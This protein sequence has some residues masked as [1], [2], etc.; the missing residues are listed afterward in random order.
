MIC[1]D[2]FRAD[3]I[4]A[5]RENPTTC[6]PHLDALCS[7]GV[8]FKQAISNQPLCSPSR[9]SFLASR[10]ATETGVWKLGLEMDH[11]L[12]TIAT[13]FKQNGYTTAFVGKWHVSAVRPVEGVDQSGWIAP[14]PSRGGFDQW[15]GANVLERV[16]HPYQGSYW[17]NDGTNIGFKDEYRVDFIT[18]RSINFIQQPHDKPWL[19]FVSQLEPH[20]QND[21][22]EFVPPKRYEK[23]FQ[24]PFV[25]MDLRNLPGNWQSH[26]PGY[27]G[28]VQAIDDCVGRLM[29][30]LEKTR[31]LDNTVVLFFSDHGCTFRTRIGEY[32]RSPH[33]ASIRVPFILAG[34]GLDRSVVS[35]EVISL[36]D[37][38]PTLLD[39]AG[40]KPPASMKGHSVLP[41][42]RDA[43]AR[44][45]WDSTV[46]LQISESMCAR[47]LRTPEW[48]Y[49]VCDP[50]IKGGEKSFSMQYTELALYSL[51]ADFPELTNLIGRPQYA[52]VSASLRELL[53]KRIVEAGEP[54]PI[55]APAQIYA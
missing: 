11:S 5:Y 48:C 2:Q 23:S 35:D 38:T 46:Y 33:E 32:K 39:A 26:L 50:S 16:S 51:S 10:Y 28:C 37:L 34:P 21:I 47:A 52:K 30:S 19:L 54:E 1:A 25:P 14:G 15:E 7:R 31:Q 29:D 53:K 22:D 13:A 44:L 8:A 55:I 43:T 6:T 42:V 17:D 20:H 40:I 49:C 18:D 27:Y 9:A 3:F 36:L 41:L 4:A 12:P 45:A 24:D